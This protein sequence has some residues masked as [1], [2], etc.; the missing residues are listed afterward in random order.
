M[1]SKTHPRFAH[2]ASAAAIVAFA[3]L[4][5]A[6]DDIHRND[7]EL[8]NT[9]FG[10]VEYEQI[11]A[12][13]EIDEVDQARSWVEGQLVVPEPGFVTTAADADDRAGPE[14]DLADKGHGTQLANSLFRSRAEA[15][16]YASEIPQDDGVRDRADATIQFSAYQ[17]PPAPPPP[18]QPIQPDQPTPSP[19]ITG[20]TPPVTPALWSDPSQLRE[21]LDQ[22]GVA[23]RGEVVRG[24]TG[25]LAASKDIGSVLTEAPTVQSAKM[26]QRS[27]VSLDPN[28]RGYKHGQIYMQAN[29]VYSMPART[30]LD[31]VFSYVDPSMIEDVVVITGPYG[32][33]HGPGFAFLDVRRKPTPR[34]DIPQTDVDLLGN[35]R[36]NG[37]Q[38]Y[39]RA[40]VL[41]GGPAYGYQFSYGHR[42]GSDYRAGDGQKIPSSYKNRDFWGEFG[43]DLDADRT[44]SFAYNRLDQTDTEYAEQFF[45]I[46]YLVHN[47]FS[48]NYVDNNACAAWSQFNA[49]LWYNTTHFQGDTDNKRNP[50]FPV[51]QRV[52]WALDDYFERQP[53]P[54][55]DPNDPNDTVARVTGITNG[56]TQNGGMRGA[57]RFGEEDELH[58]RIGA[59]VRLIEQ[60][61]DERL[62]E[63]PDFPDTVLYTNMPRAWQ[64]NPGVFAELREPLTERWTMGLGGRL[65]YAGTR[66]RARDLR[67]NSMLPGEA[68]FLEQ[69]DFLYAFY[70]TND[71]E[72]SSALTAHA[73]FGYAQRPPTLIERYADGMFLS[74]AQSAFTRVIGDPRL[75]PE[76][77]WQADFGLSVD[78]ET[79]RGK[80]TYYHAWISDYVTFADDMV[81]DITDARLLRYINT[82]LATLHGFELF[83]EFD[84]A[85][86]LT[87][88]GKMSYVEGTDREIGRSLPSIPPLE[89]TTGL[90]LHDRNRGRRWG[91]ELAARMVANQDRIGWV[92]K[93]TGVVPL[94][95]PTGG[96]TVWNLRAYYN[97]TRDFQLVAGIDNV[98]DRTYQEHLD[99]RLDGPDGPPEGSYKFPASPTRVLRPG[100]SPY[101]GLQWVF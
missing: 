87:L 28:I 76:R 50:R 71:Y 43:W 18:V 24:D 46:D 37:G 89:S 9:P 20:D 90:R 59:D 93:G 8:P 56:A 69:D 6:G 64:T 4:S 83:G 44:V 49:T 91:I 5:A 25:N 14:Q 99:G 40:T 57:F 86:R 31:S 22:V 47:G 70:L 15:A 45:D 3:W 2:A 10:Q 53:R 32:L 48:L 38:L 72:L 36:T 34:Y 82:P 35:I 63:T 12:T 27:A 11:A 100:F 96:F 58:L 65:D 19:T 77:N 29:G 54:G 67:P 41:G 13:A 26:R 30:D 81:Q 79:W 74:M 94:E 88:F 1:K 23:G 68:D 61:I 73:G 62:R 33:R 85:P 80:A 75:A 66:A 52:E 101:F 51:M 42:G 95:E 97:Y 92:R 98:F 55:F 21:R 78:H 39:G 60:R 16:D 84:V 7:S 17:P